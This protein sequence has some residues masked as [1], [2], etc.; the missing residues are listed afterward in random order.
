MTSINVQIKQQEGMVSVENNGQTLPI[1]I[2]KEHNM[3]VPEMVFGHLL[4]SDNYNDTDLKVV[5]G[6][7]G[8]G[9]K[10]TNI[11]S[12]EFILETADGT[13]KFK[14]RWMNNMTKMGT[15]E[16]V[17]SKEKSFTCVKF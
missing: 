11:F 7:N 12:L 5:G 10:L 15:R 3:Y 6:R 16:V 14:Q 8:Y 9:A 2:H 4:T 17:D 13:K 1:E